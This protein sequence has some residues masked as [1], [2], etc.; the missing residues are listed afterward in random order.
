ME[1]TQQLSFSFNPTKKWLNRIPSNIDLTISEW[2][3]LAGVS[4]SRHKY[5][6][7][8]TN[9][10][11]R[12]STYE[13]TT[14]IEKKNILIFERR[15][16]HD[17]SLGEIL[18]GLSWLLPPVK[19]LQ[20]YTTVEKGDASCILCDTWTSSGRLEEH[21]SQGKKEKELNAFRTLTLKGGNDLGDSGCSVW[22]VSNFIQEVREV[23]SSFSRNCSFRI[24]LADLW[25][26]EHLK[27]STIYY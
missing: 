6:S 2:D 1:N 4:I 11:K 21:N 3:N 15:K 23:Y 20:N 26:L 24:F 14:S 16:E 18:K 22:V 12:K 10:F 25:I 19:I 8:R 9:D 7:A 17:I 27:W 5:S 13:E